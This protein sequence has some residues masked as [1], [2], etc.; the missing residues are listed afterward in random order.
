MKQNVTIIGAGLVGS[1]L[2]I[3]MAKRGYKVNI[4]ER[5]G[6]IRKQEQIAGRSINLALSDRGLLALEKIGLTNAV[7]QVCI[8]MHNRFIHTATGGTV[9]QSY[10]KENQYINSVSRATLNMK[11]MDLAEQNGVKIF[12]NHQC[13]NIDWKKNEVFFEEKYE[14]ESR[15]YEVQST[16]EAIKNTLTEQLN[17][18]PETTND[19]E[20]TLNFD[21]LFGSDGAFSAARLQ[22]QLQHNQFNYNQYYIDCGYKELT[23]AALPNGGYAIDKNSLHIWP[24]K[25]YMMIALPN[26]DGSF[27]CTLFFPMQGENSFAALNTSEKVEA[28]FTKNFADAVPLMPNYLTDFFANPTASLVTIKCSPWVRENKF[29]LIGDAAHAIVPFFGQGMNCGFE[30]CRILDE[31]IDKHNEN[32]T[33][34]LEEYQTLRI[35]DANAIADLAVNNFYEMRDR[36]GDPQFLLQKKI[37]AR[38]H[39]KYPTKWIPAYSQ[40]T[41]SPHIRYS[42]ALKNGL[43]Q[44]EIM[45]QVMQTPNIENI[46]D[47]VEI[48]EMILARI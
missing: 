37:E 31:L 12:F 21:L 42:D 41:F 2:G 6:D 32:W 27:T 29:A 44:E 45:Q 13:K 10:G 20:I 19:K 38:L 47:S 11:L 4:Y 36:T 39:E 14:P 3:Y 15:K 34:I 43:H 17:D 16:I 33:L 28:F 30:D 18:K 7:K 40:V 9:T 23:I 25:S 24:R 26:L 8:P 48:E 1:L 22:H 35:P 5:R 46:W